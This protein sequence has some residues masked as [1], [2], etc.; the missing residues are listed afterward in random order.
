MRLLAVSALALFVLPTWLHAATARE[1]LEALEPPVVAADVALPAPPKARVGDVA[2]LFLLSDPNG[3]A[4]Q[5]RDQVGQAST[6]LL[7]IGKSPVLVGQAATPA[8]VLASVVQTSKQLR[9]D[10]VDV[11]AVSQASGVSLAGI[12]AEFDA[13]SLRDGKGEVHRMFEPAPTGFTVVAVDRAGFLRR[14]E[15]VYDVSALGAAMLRAGNCTPELEIGQPA[16]D[17]AMSDA[18]G[19]IQRLS[20]WRGQK[21]VLLTFFPKCFTG[22]C[23]NHLTSLRDTNKDFAG[24]DTEVLAVSVDPADGERGQSAFAAQLGLNFPLLPDT[25]R[26]IS[27][28]YGAVRT[29]QQNAIRMSVLIDK[30]GI[31]RV[32]DKAVQVFTHGPDMLRRVHQLEPAKR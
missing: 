4:W 20:Q 18:D 31:V 8:S 24:L 30:D 13:L 26:N 28:L 14:V 10:K 15:T 2:P 32:V 7:L 25:G 17:F 23:A 21:N 12:N 6:L 9:A 19:R 11:Y 3:K 27:L 29:T 5:S 16:P 22:G 1:S